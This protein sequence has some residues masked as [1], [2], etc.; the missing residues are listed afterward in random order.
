MLKDTM[1][2]KVLLVV[3]AILV[4]IGYLTRHFYGSPVGRE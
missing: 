3:V 2:Q 1:Q 4:G